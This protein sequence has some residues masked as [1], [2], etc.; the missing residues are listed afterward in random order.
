MGQSWAGTLD[1]IP[2]RTFSLTTSSKATV[3][4]ERGV[5][6]F[7]IMSLCWYSLF[8]SDLIIFNE[9]LDSWFLQDLEIFALK[10]ARMTRHLNPKTSYYCLGCRCPGYLAR[11][12]ICNVQ[13]GSYY[14]PPRLKPSAVRPPGTRVMQQLILTFRTGRGLTMCIQSRWPSFQG[15]KSTCALHQNLKI[16]SHIPQLYKQLRGQLHFRLCGLR[17]RKNVW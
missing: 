15:L 1:E 3:Q 16:Y 6:E 5:R 9:V 2:P 11:N 10:M 12:Y 7:C 8:K 17:A 13:Y 4:I 14:I